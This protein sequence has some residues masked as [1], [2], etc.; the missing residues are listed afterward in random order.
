MVAIVLLPGM[1]G[2]GE[3]F[4][5]FISALQAKC[6]VVPYP[7]DRPLEYDALAEL[8]RASLPS[9]EPF[10]LLGESFSGPIAIALAS[11]PPPQL[12]A[13]VLVCSFARLPVFPFHSILKRI[14]A[15]L[16]VWRA[17][18]S[19]VSRVLLGRFSSPAIEAKLK[20]AMRLVVPEVWRA[21]VRAILTVDKT[22]AVSRIRVPLLYLRASED[23]LIFPSASVVISERT[24]RAKVVELEGPHFLLQAQPEKSAVVIKAFASEHGLAL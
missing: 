3:L 12:R 23:R 6:V 9:D 7:A 14:A 13:V 19:L 11:E 10:I 20:G 15:N 22:P 24:P 5:D 2:S 18:M 16:P 21:R 4:A 17:P 8:V 1:D